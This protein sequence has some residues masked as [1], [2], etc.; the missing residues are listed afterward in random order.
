MRRNKTQ[1]WLSSHRADYGVRQAQRAGWRSRSALKL[2]ELDKSYDLFAGKK[3]IVDLGAAPGGW[4]QVA[5]KLAPSSKLVAV[6]LLSMKPLSGVEVIQ[7]DCL[8]E[9]VQDQIFTALGGPADLVICDMAPNLTGIRDLDEEQLMQLHHGTLEF[10]QTHANSGAN[11]VL[12]TFTWQSQPEIK[13]LAN[14]LFAQV[15][16][17]NLDATKK[18]SSEVYLIA[19]TLQRH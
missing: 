12:K 10:C 1:R 15:T 14:Q 7:G 5:S 17:R 16:F 18:G 9:S 19:K 2:I 8:E 11:L 4:C 3:R 13:Q 6:D